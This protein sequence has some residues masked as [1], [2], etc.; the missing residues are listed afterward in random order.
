MSSLPSSGSKN[1]SG[2][3]SAGASAWPK[4][5]SHQSKAS[6]LSSDAMRWLAWERV[7]SKL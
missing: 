2:F 5:A 6:A 1:D 3:F 4:A 7:I